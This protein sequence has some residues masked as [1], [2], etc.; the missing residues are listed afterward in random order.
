MP[1]VLQGHADSGPMPVQS[2][3]HGTLRFYLHQTETLGGGPFAPA[4]LV[5]HE[6][7]AWAAG[8]GVGREGGRG[9]N[10]SVVATIAS[11]ATIATTETPAKQAAATAPCAAI[12]QWTL[13]ALERL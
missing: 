5:E 13:E 9:G 10:L 1:L 2:H 4:R 7:V 3:R 6:E 8:E 11:I 12:R